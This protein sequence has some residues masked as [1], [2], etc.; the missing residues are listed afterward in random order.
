MDYIEGQN[1]YFNALPNIIPSSSGLKG[2]NVAIQNVDAQTNTYS[3]PAVPFPDNVIMTESTKLD[4]LAKKCETSSQDQLI[5]AQNPND[6]VGCGWMYTPPPKNSPYPQ[7]SKGAVG[8]VNGPYTKYNPTAD[9]KK[10]FFDLQEA[11]RVQLLDKCK[12]L[13]DCKNVDESVY[14]DCGYCTDINQGIPVDKNGQPL[15]PNSH[16]GGCSPQSIITKS[17]KCPEPSGL[18]PVPITN[19]TCDAINGRLNAMCL[20]NTVISGGCSDKGALATALNGSPSPNDY[21]SNLN[22]SESV[23]MYNRIANPPFKL[24]VFRQGNATVNE[25]LKEVRQMAS[26]TQGN[27]QLNMVARDLCLQKGAANSFDFCSDLSDSTLPPFDLTCLQVLFKKLGGQPAG[28]AYPSTTTITTYN[29]MANLGAIKQYFNGL[30]RNMKSNDYN[31]QRDS[32]IK[33][34]GIA[35]E[36]MVKR[37][38][39][40]QGVEIFWFQIVPGTNKLG[41][42]LRRTIENDIVQFPQGDTSIISQVGFTQYSSYMAITDVRASSD[43]S[44]KWQVNVDDGFYISVNQP[45]EFDFYASQHLVEDSPG[46]FS[47][48]QMNPGSYNSNSCSSFSGTFP[49]ITKFFY[50]DS[51]GGAHTL[52]IGNTACSG[53]SVLQPSY[54]SLTLEKRAP[55][56]NYEVNL[57]T[58]VFEDTRAPQ[59]F[60]QFIN[61]LNTQYYTNTTD[62][63]N[64]PGNKGFIR[65]VNNVSAISIANIAFQGWCTCTFAFRLKTMPIKDTLVYLASGAWFINIYLTPLSSNSVQVNILTNMPTGNGK[66]AY[67]LNLDTWYLLFMANKGPTGGIDL[68]INTIDSLSKDGSANVY[69]IS[70]NGAPFFLQNGLNVNNNA[71]LI[72]FGGANINGFNNSVFSFD[73][74]FIH[75]FDQYTNGDDIK[76]DSLCNWIYTQF[77]DSYNSYKT[78]GL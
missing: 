30:I 46:Y 15:Y 53:T 21:L 37:A 9:Y 34:L 19:N 55:F 14:S 50:Q 76:R 35:P 27:S 58:S 31:I 68:Y 22:G 26:V 3:V 25:V 18:G 38:P 57:N 47:N 4:G 73:T 43:F 49:N 59:V 77:P 56:I 63:N 44:V 45:K 75:F 23:K 48:N 36:K 74:A 8:D 13:K 65:H 70:T 28:T 71:C 17:N 42:F 6:P 54:Y 2:F 72:Q 67:I 69:T 51:G 16:M 61:T 5:A 7:V 1:K 64:V 60:S 52:Q 62:R 32:L 40:S 11:K 20:Y 66:T 12:S 41:G 78:M 24:D 29:T 39:P 10:W 33:F